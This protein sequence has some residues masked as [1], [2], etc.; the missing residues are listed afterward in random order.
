MLAAKQL[1]L[2]KIGETVMKTAF[3]RFDKNRNGRLELNEA[4]AA[5][6]SLQKSSGGSHGHY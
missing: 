4:L 5:I 2:G 6:T 3:R 1:G